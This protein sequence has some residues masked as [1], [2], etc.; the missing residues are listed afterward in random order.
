MRARTL[1]LVCGLL[2]ATAAVWAGPRVALETDLGRIVIELDPE[3][4]PRTVDNFLRYVR[5]GFYDGTVFHR[6][7]PGFVIQG[8]GYT[9]RLERKPTHGPVPNESDNGLSNRRGTVAMA[10][11]RDP[12]SA[13]SQFFIN[14]AD[15]VF[16]DHRPPMARPSG[17][18]VFGRVVEGME[19]VDAIARRPT[20]PAGSFPQDVPRPPVVIRSARLLGTA[21][22]GR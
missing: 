4:A 17:Y 14:L 1:L 10:R 16:L 9:A 6:V 8:G 11:T 3:R 15:N 2:A 12:D 5:E 20:G 22:T 18:T 19:V 21:G 13:T 7:V